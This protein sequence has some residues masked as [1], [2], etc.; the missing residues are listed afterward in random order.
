MIK[1]ADG[2]YLY[3]LLLLPIIVAGYISYFIIR[4]KTLLKTVDAQL[5][6][7][8]TD[9]VDW[10]K[11][12]L[13]AV[14]FIL[15]FV[16]VV[17]AAARPKWGETLQIYKGRGIDIVIGIDASKSMLA[18]D[19]KPNRLARAKTEVSALIDN[20]GTNRIGITAFA[21]DCYVMCPLTTDLEAAKMFLDIIAPEMIPIPGTNFAKAI[22]VSASLFDPKDP[23]YKALILI[24][25][26]EDLGENPIPIA[27]QVAEQGVKIFSVL[28]ATQE[29]APIPEKDQ[30]G[31]LIAYKKDKKGE[32]V[33]SR[34]NENLLIIISRLSGGRYYRSETMSLDNLIAELDRIKKKE[35]GGGE[36][37][38][39]VERYQPF[40]LIGFV[41]LFLGMF[42]SDRK[43][44]WFEFSAI[45]FRR[46]K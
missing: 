39:Y 30:A 22:Q 33:M 2:Q 37:V 41:L 12:I 35:I 21:G 34:P 20:L 7:K 36:Y 32:M 38:E 8:L 3:F 6:A 43:G 18:E 9:T 4:R 31:N 13:Q 23:S 24:T 11:K 15:G 29:G 14:L 26:G 16:L 46:K 44:H 10:R 28:I 5:V 27:Q 45:Y 1:W 19:I 25:D 42:V 40:L 17:I